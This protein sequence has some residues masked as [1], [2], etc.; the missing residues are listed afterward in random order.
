[1]KILETSPQGLTREEAS[2]RR[3]LY[4]PNKVQEVRRL[5]PLKLFLEQFKNALNYI[6]ILAV[7]ISIVLGDTLDALIVIV[8]LLF[9]ATLGFVQE[10]RSEK[11]LEALKELS[12]PKTIVVREGKEREI[13]T[14]ELVPGDLVILNT[15]DKVPADIRLITSIRL[16]ALE[17]I[18]T[19]EAGSEEKVTGELPEDTPLVDRLNMVYSG[20][21]ITG[22]KGSG[23]VVATGMN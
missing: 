15:G 8:I 20:T 11:A 4:G 9:N 21:V 3:E 22:G 13:R 5:S 7:A 16:R 12:A 23:I 2:R 19:G 18:L 6:L 1:M 10:Y 17:S 14:E